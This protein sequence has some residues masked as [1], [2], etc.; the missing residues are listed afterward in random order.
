M[1]QKERGN[2]SLRRFTYSALLLMFLGS[3]ESCKLY[4]LGACFIFL[5]CPVFAPGFN[6]GLLRN[7]AEGE[8]ELITL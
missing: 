2:Q 6:C 7:D 8:G 5:M 4:L 3:S 1:M